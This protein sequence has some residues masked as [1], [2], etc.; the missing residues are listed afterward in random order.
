MGFRGRTSGFRSHRL[1]IFDSI[2]IPKGILDILPTMN[3][4][5]T[6]RSNRTRGHV[7]KYVLQFAVFAA[8]SLWVLYQITQPTN[9][10]PPLRR[11]V[12]TDHLSN[13]LGRKG[14]PGISKSTPVSQSALTLQDVT[15]PGEEGGIE[16]IEFRRKAVPFKEGNGNENGNDS[17]TLVL[18][19][20][21][22]NITYPDENG[23]PQYVRDKFV[24]IET[25]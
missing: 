6:P 24:G 21:K 23:I 15:N 22:S 10:N 16:E 25:S 7:I 13:F 11:H 1:I 20:A 9:N 8:F 12:S 18:T 14:N 17:N 3:H 2:R 5:M 19:V 4:Q